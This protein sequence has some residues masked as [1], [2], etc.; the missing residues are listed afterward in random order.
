MDLGIQ[1][2]CH[3]C[4][5]YRTCNLWLKKTQIKDKTCIVDCLVNN[6]GTQTL[7]IY[8]SLLPWLFYHFVGCKNKGSCCWFLH[9]HN[10]NYKMLSIMKTSWQLQPKKICQKNLNGKL[11]T[12]GDTIKITNKSY[13]YGIQREIDHKTSSW[14]CMFFYNTYS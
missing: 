14:V 13:V 4:F 1:S 6:F 5:H 2:H 12:G 3:G 11:N 7:I 10:H 8:L 9:P